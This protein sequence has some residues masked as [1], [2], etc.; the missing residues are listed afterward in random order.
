[1]SNYAVG[2]ESHPSQDLWVPNLEHI[3]NITDRAN[4]SH[5]HPIRGHTVERQPAKPITDHVLP[6]VFHAASAE[7]SINNQIHIL[8]GNLTVR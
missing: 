1:M 3:K 2:Y 4:H 7:I 8:C 5:L 6:G